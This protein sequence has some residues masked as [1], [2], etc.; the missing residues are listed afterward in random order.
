MWITLLIFAIAAVVGL[1]MALAVMQGRFPPVASAVIHGVLAASALVLLIVAVL[2]QGA[3]G[4]ARW[5][6]GFFLVAALGGFVL[7]LGYHARKRNLPAG[8]VIGHAALAV[9][10]FLLLLAGALHLM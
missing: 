4:A 2:V 7:A 10:G 1:T 8:F 5:A 6:L 9:I 3:T